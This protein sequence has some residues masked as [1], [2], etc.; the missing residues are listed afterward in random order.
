MEKR[1]IYGK[2]RT[3]APHCETNFEIC[4]KEP[5]I[6]GRANVAIIEALAKHFKVPL[7]K[8]RLVS[9]FS[10]RQKVLEIEN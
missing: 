5:P 2:G 6:K 7:S 3:W 1:I 9:G 4:V 8:V 10:S